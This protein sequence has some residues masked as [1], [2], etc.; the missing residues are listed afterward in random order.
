MQVTVV[1]DKSRYVF[2]R[3]MLK[4]H[5]SDRLED[6]EVW[7]TSDRKR[8][9][10]NVYYTERLPLDTT[11]YFPSEYSRGNIL[12]EGK[13]FLFDEFPYH[14]ETNDQKLKELLAQGR[15][16]EVILFRTKREC[17]ET[18]VTT[19]EEA[20]ERAEKEYR[21]KGVVVQSYWFGQRP[22]FLFAVHSDRNK[23]SL[24]KSAFMPLLHEVQEK[25][26]HFDSDYSF[27]MEWEGVTSRLEPDILNT[28]FVYQ[29]SLENKNI[30]EIACMDSK[31]F[32]LEEDSEMAKFLM[33]QYR[34]LVGE[35]CQWDLKYD[36][37]DFL[38]QIR[39]E[40]ET[41]VLAGYG[42]L[43]FPED[44]MEY[45][46]CIH[47]HRREVAEFKRRIQCFF[48]ERTREIIK[49]RVE[50]YKKK[51]EVWMK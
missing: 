16:A 46:G 40:Y 5:F 34:E 41:Y 7:L 30:W 33:Q 13:I 19:E 43:L 2:L 24:M 44:E 37:L 35:L 51:M 38:G 25:V 36:T 12:N 11:L 17:L 6:R 49:N 47:Q 21:K 9:G 15:Q 50:K 45:I 22:D 27:Q 42:I 14:T 28:F 32:Y 10:E 4:D 26:K 8:K 39:E 31:R 20:L 18:D 29:K 3:N 23:K 48:Y 1:G